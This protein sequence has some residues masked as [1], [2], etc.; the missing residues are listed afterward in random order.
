MCARL[1]CVYV[2]AHAW[3]YVAIVRGPDNFRMHA[4]RSVAAAHTHVGK[5]SRIQAF[6]SESCYLSINQ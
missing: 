3:V 1:M 2:R 6:D 4:A 5:L